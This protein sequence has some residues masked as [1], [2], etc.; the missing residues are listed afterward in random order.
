MESQGYLNAFV[1]YIVLVAPW[2]EADVIRKYLR[3]LT[4]P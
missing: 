4:S 2:A 1:W 3:S